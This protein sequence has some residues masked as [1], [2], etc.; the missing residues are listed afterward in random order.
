MLSFSID[1]T[2][3]QT[4]TEEQSEVWNIMEKLYEAIKAS[5]HEKY[6]SFLHANY[7]NWFDNETFPSDRASHD[8]WEANW[9]ANNEVKIYKS[10]HSE[11][12]L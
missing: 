9:M 8:M 4:W 10:F 3:A 1:P 5:D 6:K 7:S 2:Y 12:I 11:S